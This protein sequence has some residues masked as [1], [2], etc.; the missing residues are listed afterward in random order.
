[1]EIVIGGRL[2]NRCVHEEKIEFF[3]YPGLTPYKHRT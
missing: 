3:A 1:M 2:G